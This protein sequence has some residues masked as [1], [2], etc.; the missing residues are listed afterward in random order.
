M[1]SRVLLTTVSFHLGI[2]RF[3]ERDVS[4]YPHGLALLFDH[5]GSTSGLRERQIFTPESIKSVLFVKGKER[6]LERG[7]SPS[8]KEF[9]SRVVL[10]KVTI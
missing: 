1:A 9:E 4:L 5:A 8:R 2:H 6:R 7:V 10:K 3:V